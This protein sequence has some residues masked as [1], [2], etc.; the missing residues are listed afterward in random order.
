MHYQ[1]IWLILL[2]VFAGIEGIT[3]GLV[4][5]WFLTYIASE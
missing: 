1:T 2:I 5:I 3:A 4:S